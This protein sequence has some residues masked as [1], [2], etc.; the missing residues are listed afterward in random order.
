MRSLDAKKY[1]NSLIVSY[2][3][4]LGKTVEPNS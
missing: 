4:H 3:Q 2:N 1:L